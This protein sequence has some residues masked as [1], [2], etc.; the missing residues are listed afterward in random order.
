MYLHILTFDYIGPP[1][2]CTINEIVCNI[3]SFWFL[4][5]RLRGKMAWQNYNFF[6]WNST[7]T[8]GGKN[9]NCCD[10]IL[11]CNTKLFF[12]TT[13]VHKHGKCLFSQLSCICTELVLTVVFSWKWKPSSMFQIPTYTYLL[14]FLHYALR[15]ILIMMND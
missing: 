13:H 7:Y 14:V 6:V 2:V 8:C 3:F 12:S 9:A 4:V 10:F 5:G 1:H 11:S 15:C